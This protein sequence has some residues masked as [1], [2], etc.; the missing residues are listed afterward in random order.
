[1]LIINVDIR[2]KLIFQKIPTIIFIFNGKLV[3]IA[4]QIQ[5]LIQ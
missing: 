5:I 3:Q 1:M 2:K 4:V